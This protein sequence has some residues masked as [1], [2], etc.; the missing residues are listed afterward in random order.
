[1]FIGSPAGRTTG[2]QGLRGSHTTGHL[3]TLSEPALRG[4]KYLLAGFLLAALWL[5]APSAGVP[6]GPS[7]A[8][9]TGAEVTLTLLHNNDGESALLEQ[10]NVFG[11]EGE[12][13]SVAVGSIAAYKAVVD[14]ET[15]LARS[16]GNAVINV[17]AGD[18]Y[19]A[20]ANLLCGRREGNPLFDAIAQQAIDYDAHVI[21]NHEFDSGPDLF[22]RFVRAL[23]PH[24]FL[25]ANLDFAAEPGFGDLIDDDGL[26]SGADLEAPVIGRSMVVD[27]QPTGARFGLIGATTPSL[28]Q[29]SVPRDVAVT[30]DLAST[31]GAVQA[32]VDRLLALGV[33]RIIFVSHLQSIANDVELVG[34]LRG[35]DV[36]VAGGGGELLTNPEVADSLQVLPGESAEADAT[37]PFEVL[38][39]DGRTVYVVTTTGNYRYLGRL[40]VKF[41]AAGEVSRV[42]GEESYP[43]P[44]RPADS[45]SDDGAVAKDVGLVAAVELPLR[46]CLSELAAV[47]VASTEVLLEHSREA[48][49]SRETNTA[50][51]VVDAFVDSFE[52]HGAANGVP[53]SAWS[54]PV[55]GLQNG[56]GIRQTGGEFLPVDGSVPGPIYLVGLLDLLP[57]GNSIVVIPDVRAA[58]LKDAFELSVSRHPEPNGGFLHVAGISVTYDPGREPGSRVRS[59]TLANGDAIVN[60]GAVIAE[61]PRLTVVTNSF[62][63]GGGNGY[64]MLA[65]YPGQVQLPVSDF[66]ALL[67]Y[68]EHL[69]NVS[70]GDARYAA[71]GDGRIRFAETPLAPAAVESG[72]AQEPTPAPSSAV[73][74]DRQDSAPSPGPSNGA[75]IALAVAIVPLLAVFLI[76]AAWWIGRPRERPS[77]GRG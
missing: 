10:I 69:G 7:A 21:G 67:G 3:A 46:D 41:D 8:A 31:A 76:A 12:R 63:A 43:R 77:R 29:V 11:P 61:A 28:P 74:S 44:V 20:G 2:G 49:R 25:S 62:V 19:L 38:D 58:S 17:Y 60:A 13:E 30:P 15:A 68:L 59:L 14:R 22:E 37:Y 34:Q 1:M 50:N 23:G 32:E 66:E 35:V 33:N 4:S 45:G 57:F 54:N 36:A 75:Q 52:R 65:G 56:G 9:D 16:A 26:I 18:A 72:Q 64:E 47:K 5:V 73:K 39:A 71:S 48:V 53:D 55:I 70:A 27:D 24:P 40:D 51:L 6:A 42:V